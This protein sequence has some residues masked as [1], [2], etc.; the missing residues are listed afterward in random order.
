MTVARVWPRAP[1]TEARDAVL[2]LLTEPGIVVI[3]G[4][5]GAGKSTLA[6]DAAEAA[7]HPFR[8]VTAIAVLR[9]VEWGALSP[10]LAAPGD[11]ASAADALCPPGR[12][13]L[14]LVDD[15]DGLD[16]SSAATL[17]IVAARGPVL[18]TLRTGAVLPA[19][20]TARDV[21]DIAP[22]SPAD[23]T[24]LLTQL[25]GGPFERSSAHALHELTAGSPLLL[26]H[27][28]RTEE[29]RM[30]FHRSNGVWWWDRSP[31]LSTSILHLVGDE[32]SDAP[33]SAR[34]VI[35]LVVAAGDVPVTTAQALRGAPAVDAA[36]A[37][38]VVVA[39]SGRLRLRLP[40]AREL[41]A[42]LFPVAK[43]RAIAREA[44]DRLATEPDDA[45]TLLRA[46]LLAEHGLAD[47][48]GLLDG[49]DVA[50][51][52][53][54]PVLATRL[55]AAAEEV[56]LAESSSRVVELAESSSRVVE[57]TESSSRVMELADQP[58]ARPSYRASYLGALARSWSGDGHGAETC[59][60]AAARSA[61]SDA[62]RTAVAVL[63]FSNA[64]FTIGVPRV[65]VAALEVDGRPLRGA[66]AESLAACRALL[67]V[68]AG[69][70]QDALA[71]G[72]SAVAGASVPHARVI[73]GIAVVQALS[74]LGRSDEITAA[75]APALAAVDA[76]TCDVGGLRA[77]LALR[78]A[79]ALVA[80]GYLAEAGEVVAGAGPA[81]TSG[82][83]RLQS[84]ALEAMVTLAEGRVRTAVTLIY[85][86]LAG[87][88]RLRREKDGLGYEDVA[89]GQLVR[90]LALIRDPVAARREADVLAGRMRP[91]YVSL[92]PT[93]ALAL[94]WADAAEGVL[95]EAARHAQESAALARAAGSRT[96]E[97]VGLYYAAQFGE[98]DVAAAE[99]AAAGIAG[100]RAVAML[101]YV[102]ALA[103]RDAAGLRAASQLF[104]DFGDTLSA[105][106]AAAQALACGD[107]S[108]GELASLLAADCEGGTTPAMAA[109]RRGAATLTPRQREIAQLV[110]QGLSN[111]AIA[112]RLVTSVRTVEGHIY[113]ICR[114]IGVDNRDALARRLRTRMS[115]RHPTAGPR[116]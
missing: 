116:R 30:R 40:L 13:G 44:V 108:A 94:A 66:D 81:A 79:H 98:P 96:S 74:D 5:A 103:R 101:A 39:E 1:R 76:G 21:V 57:L 36:L 49:A 80:G 68:G 93:A 99:A 111:K 90:A 24:E 102:G 70:P 86:V 85:D 52:S 23:V 89:R 29:R 84:R 48:R 51:R 107:A 6:H 17:A 3:T 65:A 104:L 4:H 106:D 82:P 71:A 42:Q 83:G 7:G 60:I 77:G 115:A 63:R 2:A 61:R 47:A 73:A 20:L 15:A 114:A 53:D 9:D 32:L 8:H 59:C 67:A 27:L 11:P 28:V 37:S 113:R 64:M 46:S 50:L 22:L 105:A 88:Q 112:E 12:P 95:S 62:E 41:G 33:E 91:E 109:L 19:G 14:V 69:R 87:M 31:A 75:I 34:P 92:R 25:C 100:P 43:R 56:E 16:A 38:G 110:R 35:D 78:H 97:L 45:S 58:Q 72:L 18:V 55:A 10:L 54:D 26:R